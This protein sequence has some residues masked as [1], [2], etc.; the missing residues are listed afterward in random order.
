MKS[1]DDAGTVL[2][3]STADYPNEILIY[4][5]TKSQ[6]QPVGKGSLV[7]N[8]DNTPDIPCYHDNTPDI[9][10]YH[11]KTPDILELTVHN[12]VNFFAVEL[13]DGVWH[14]VCVAWG[15]ATAAKVTG[16]VNLMVDGAEIS[17][18]KTLAGSAF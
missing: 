12:R 15:T 8:H 9:P 18:Y 4:L 10:C 11:E 5:S 14:S 3:Y 17:Q 1:A 16:S 2:R 7:C 13:L 6:H